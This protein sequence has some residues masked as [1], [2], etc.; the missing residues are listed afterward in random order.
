MIPLL[1]PSDYWKKSHSLVSKFIWGGKQPRVKLTTLQ[2]R[3]MD[4]SLSMPNFKHYF[5]SFVLIPQADRLNIDS[6]PCWKPIEIN[7]ASPHRL[8]DL[9]YTSVPLKRARLQLG[10]IMS[11][12]L[13]MWHLAEKESKSTCKWHRSSPLFNNYSL[14]SA[15]IPFSSS[16][17][18]TKGIHTLA[19]V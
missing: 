18:S 6:S 1:P 3:K 12:L 16:A 10:P 19:D 7:L 11:F 4:G 15:G 8:E 13:S 5:W 2:R 9:I 14:L 17:W